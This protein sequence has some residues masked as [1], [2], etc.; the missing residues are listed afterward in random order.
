MFLFTFLHPSPNGTIVIWVNSPWVYKPILIKSYMQNIWVLKLAAIYK[1]MLMFL[2]VIIFNN[3]QSTLYKVNSVV[4]N[5]IK[6][7]N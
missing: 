1:M 7:I 6:E 2:L 5:D 3:N 4:S